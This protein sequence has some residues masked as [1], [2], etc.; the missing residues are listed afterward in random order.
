MD[1]LNFERVRPAPKNGY[2]WAVAVGLG[3][4]ERR[5]AL[6]ALVVTT[7]CYMAKWPRFCFKD[8]CTLRRFQVTPDEDDDETTNR[9]FIIVP[10][11]AAAAGYLFF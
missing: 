11:V 9:H 8:N 1:E 7:V 5:A 2:E 10:V 6:S 4:P 3:T